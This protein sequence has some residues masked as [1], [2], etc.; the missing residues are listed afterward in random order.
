MSFELDRL[1]AY[2]RADALRI[3]A[4]AELRGLGMYTDEYLR[5]RDGLLFVRICLLFEQVC[6]AMDREY[7]ERAQCRRVV[8][9][10]STKSFIHH[11]LL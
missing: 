3:C 8:A 1:H 7:P 11:P 6:L 2:L 10:S 4:A 5:E 9:V